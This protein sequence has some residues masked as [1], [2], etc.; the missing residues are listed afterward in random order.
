MMKNKIIKDSLINLPALSPYSSGS[1]FMVA[2]D[3]N[4][5]D[6]INLSS[7]DYAKKCESYMREDPNV[8]YRIVRGGPAAAS[9]RL[10]DGLTQVL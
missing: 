5:S 8:K 2:G 9:K 6:P 10:S 7:A 1:N 4:G 3:R